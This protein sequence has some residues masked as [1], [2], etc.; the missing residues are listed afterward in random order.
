MIPLSQFVNH[1][2]AHPTMANHDVNVSFEAG[3][4][5]F[6]PDKL[7]MGKGAGVV[8]LHRAPPPAAPQWT[9]VDAK[10]KNDDDNQFRSEVISGG[11]KLL[12]HDR[13]T[14]GGNYDYYVIVAN[15]SETITSPDPQIINSGPEM[16]ASNSLYIL[17]GAVVGAIAGALVDM[18]TGPATSRGMM[19]GLALG[20]LLGAI[21]GA[22][23]GRMLAGRRSP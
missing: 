8:T 16:M 7:P 15:G 12:I 5:T 10:V 17:V 19:R 3:K 20:A 14:K 18:N 1:P 21:L 9:F 13:N 2:S 22:L 11:A 6:T 23:L 4:F